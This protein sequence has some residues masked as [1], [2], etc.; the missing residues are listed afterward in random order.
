MAARGRSSTLALE[1]SYTSWRLQ[2]YAQEMG[3]DGP[4]FR[5]GP[6]RRALLRADLGAVFLHVYRLSRPGAEHVLDSFV[7][8]REYEVRDHGEY[9]TRR[10]VLDAYDRKAAATTGGTAWAPLAPVPAGHGPPPAALDNQEVRHPG[11][12]RRPRLR[13]TRIDRILFCCL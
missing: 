2:P 1:L 5:R 4:P 3:D 11:E 8:V 7:V 6:E 13:T 12:A 9:R 10:L